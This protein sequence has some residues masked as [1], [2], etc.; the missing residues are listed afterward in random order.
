MNLSTQSEEKVRSE[1]SAD[2]CTLFQF[3]SVLYPIGSRA[4][5]FYLLPS[6][7]T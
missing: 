2:D 6:L 5:R 7:L 4:L 1:V 3:F